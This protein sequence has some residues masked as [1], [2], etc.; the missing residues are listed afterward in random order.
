MLLLAGMGLGSA[1]PSAPGYVGVYQFVAVEV[2]TPFGFTR[3]QALA[4]IL[5]T[6]AAGY[7]VVLTWG[8]PALL[9]MRRGPRQSSASAG[10]SGSPARK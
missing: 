8:L 4:F 6:Q 3:D 2:L 10:V 1:L 5:V 7:A 9:M